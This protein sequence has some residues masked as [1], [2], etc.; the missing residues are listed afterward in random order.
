[1]L[2]PAAPLSGSRA[3]FVPL[4]QN[5]GR[6][7]AGAFAAQQAPGTKVANRSRDTWNLL[8]WGTIRIQGQAEAHAWKSTQLP[9]IGGSRG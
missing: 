4:G 5:A 7:N 1:M 2:E 3:T 8:S 6:S 9:G